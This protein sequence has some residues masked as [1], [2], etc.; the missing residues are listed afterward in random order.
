MQLS[1]TILEAASATRVFR[2][3]A[4]PCSRVRAERA[5]AQGYSAK[6]GLQSHTSN[7]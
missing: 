5:E 2:K 3:P 1:G 6:P 7:C 4:R